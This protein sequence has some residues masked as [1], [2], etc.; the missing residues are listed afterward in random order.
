MHLA[1]G[2]IPV[3]RSVLSEG[4]KGIDETVDKMVAMA[5]GPYGAR[6]AKIRALAI[7]ILNKARVENKDYYGMIVAV[8]EWVRDNIRYVRDPIGQ[9]T[10]SYPEE[11]AFNSHAGDC[12]AEG[13]RVLTPTGY[14]NIED[15]EPGDTIQG[16][17]G[18][19]KVLKW[20]DK[21]TLPTHEYTLDNGGDFVAT[22]DHRCFLLEGGEKRAGELKVRDALLGP[23][24]ITL[25]DEANDKWT[26]ADFYFFGL[27]IADGWCAEK[28]TCIAGKDG[29]AKEAQKHW[30]Q[31]YAA[32]K[33]W[34]THWHSRYIT[35]YIPANHPLYA[36]CH[37]GRLAPEKE[38]PPEL[39]AVLTKPRAQ[40]LLDGLFADSHD[41]NASRRTI[42]AEQGRKKRR[43]RGGVCH[44]T[45]SPELAKQ[46][47]L[48]LRVLGFSMRSSLIV[49]HG[50]F[51]LHPVFRNYPRY[52]KNKP[53]KIESIRPVGLRHVYDLQTA[54]SG[55]YLPDA[56]V[57]V[58]NCDD[59]VILVMG[60]LG[61]IGLKSY[62]VCIGMVPNSFSHVYAYAEVP[63]GKHRNAGQTIAVD[64][65]MREWPIGKEAPGGKVQA[66]KT[67]SNL[68]GDAMLGAYTLSPSYLDE[69]QSADVP[70]A[71]KRGL[72]DAGGYG[73]IF[74]APKVDQE[75]NEIDEIFTTDPINEMA[76][77]G[78]AFLHN[79]G[80]MTAAGDAGKNVFLPSG[81]TY[82][83]S[84]MGR[85]TQVGKK[86]KKFVDV[87]SEM[88][89]ERGKPAARASAPV[90]PTEEE[91]AGIG[92]MLA[93]LGAEIK[94]TNCSMW[95]GVNG[96]ADPV[97]K[98]ASAAA[99]ARQRYRVAKKVVTSFMP[100]LGRD[101][102][103]DARANAAGRV[104]QLAQ[105]IAAA[106]RQL[107]DIAAGSSPMRKAALID[108]LNTL[109][110]LDKQGFIRAVDAA[111]LPEGVT[112]LGIAKTKTL[113]IS[114][115]TT[116]PFVA[117]PVKIRSAVMT[118]LPAGAVVRDRTGR[119][120][121]VDG[122][123]GDLG[124]PSWA[125]PVSII[126][127]ARDA[128]SGA[129]KAVVAVPRKA[130]QATVQASTQA[131]KAAASSAGQ[132]VRQAAS[133]ASRVVKQAP[134]AVA[135]TVR[136]VGSAAGQAT[137]Q[138]AA[139]VAQAPSAIGT[140]ARDVGSAAGASVR[141][142]ASG[143]GGIVRQA[144]SEVGQGVSSAGGALRQAGSSVSEGL[145]QAG[146]S[147]SDTLKTA[148]RQA[149]ATVRNIPA[150]AADFI[151]ENRDLLMASMGGPMFASLYTGARGALETA[152]GIV[153][154]HQAAGDSGE[155]LD[156]NG[157]PIGTPYQ[158]SNGNTITA[159][160]YYDLMNPSGKLD[161]NGYPEG[162][163]YTDSNGNTITAQQY[164][165]LMHPVETSVMQPQFDINGNPLGTSYVDQAGNSITAEQYYQANQAAQQQ[166][167]TQTG[168]TGAGYSVPDTSGGYDSG[169]MYPDYSGDS[170]G[171][172]QSFDYGSGPTFDSSW[173]EGGGS[174]DFGPDSMGPAED[175]AYA[176]DMEAMMDEG[177]SEESEFYAEDT[178]EDGEETEFV[179][180][181]VNTD[182]EPEVAEAATRPTT[183][184]KRRRRQAVAQAS[185]NTEVDDDSEVDAPG[186]GMYRMSGLGALPSASTL[187][188]LAAVGVGIYLLTRK[189]RK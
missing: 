43:G 82:S 121:D 2:D 139:T 147:F 57:V 63:P 33:G 52:Y 76:P 75:M 120:I 104:A 61:S 10:L 87:P 175:A 154:K 149:G 134:S 26:D 136:D 27:Y 128:V 40:R 182:E 68:A 129:L 161:I 110:K 21:G 170:G 135:A 16:K 97:H 1:N 100:G 6:S 132:T 162:T 126:D 117:S 80:P 44:S 65:I 42:G 50:G 22:D 146:S 84:G 125:N 41:P 66:K 55:I 124:W 152:M 12:L 49:D 59:Q 74:T 157:N 31:D 70:R 133:A 90:A 36:L 164:Y 73:E 101:P 15:V 28:K 153:A 32:A 155:E 83:S 19:T 96:P 29:F 184:P 172:D 141:Q 18:W 158:D 140:A 168:G 79:R 113:A 116:L 3:S 151:D 78:S 99:Y 148:Y 8:G 23:A 17:S 112:P 160:Q 88:P 169:S 98:A 9:E 167:Q 114:K 67:Y 106:A 174:S 189:N 7:N 185:N 143:A 86:G 60:L 156:I 107:A 180:E 45:T 58:H 5:K 187:L 46:V 186:E 150:T 163:P 144:A 145:K 181:I 54:D 102:V 85:V 71:M 159:Q 81:K 177:G 72:V 103:F 64:T 142:V 137:K 173:T 127:R 4:E 93:S 130:I 92:D 14:K 171:G 20:W 122:M 188:P 48:L 138:V 105:Q 13:T 176:T 11:T 118:P 123:A 111:P 24:D 25:P 109:E 94:A 77:A 115:E 165:D 178:G 183:K 35:I 179:D 47:R 34:R 95:Q 119:V 131:V 56:D 62:P 38:L 108:D 37:D 53:A 39:L 51:G 166:Y 69:R 91:L 30:C 89:Y